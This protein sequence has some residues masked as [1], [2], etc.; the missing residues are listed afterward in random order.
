MEI[1]A[2]VAVA[3]AAAT[4]G[5]RPLF[6]G[7]ADSSRNN[8]SKSSRKCNQHQNSKKHQSIHPPQIMRRILCAATNN[9]RCPITVRCRPYVCLLAFIFIFQKIN[10]YFM[11]DAE[12]Q[13]SYR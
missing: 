12:F 13:A 9:E 11:V 10:K 2:I 5:Q 7:S 1:A 6:H 8:T 4:S 3:V